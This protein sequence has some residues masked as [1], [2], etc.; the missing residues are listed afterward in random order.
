MIRQG[1]Q[2]T[3]FVAAGRKLPVV[4]HVFTEA[5][6]IAMPTRRW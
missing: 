1:N 2:V 6:P 3:R 5:T 4:W